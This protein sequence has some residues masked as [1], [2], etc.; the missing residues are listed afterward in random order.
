MTE[1]LGGQ[2]PHSFQFEIAV[3]QEQRQDVL[4]H[5]ATGKGK[6]FVAAAPYKLQHNVDEKRVTLMVSPLI[7]LQDEMVETFKDEFGIDA[8]AINSNHG[9]LNRNV[10]DRVVNGDFRIV[11]LAPEVLL[12][13]IFIDTVLR[14]KKFLQRIYSVV[15]D[16]AHCISHWGDSFRKSYSNVGGIRV[17]LPKNTP[18]IAVSATLTR[19][20]TRDIISKLQLG[21]GS[22]FVYINIG[23]DRD[24][25]SLAVRAIHHAQK[26]LSDVGFVVPSNTQHREDIPKTWIYA[27]DIKEGT[28]ITNYLNE[29]LPDHL[30]N[31]GL[32]REYSAVFN[33]DYRTAAMN[34]F[35]SG[36]IRILVCTDAAGMGCNI[37]DVDVVVQWGLPKTLSSFVQRAGRA[38]RGRGKVGL[39]VLLCEPSAYMVDLTKAPASAPRKKGAPSKL[40]TDAAASAREAS[41]AYAVAHGRNRGGLS[42]QDDLLTAQEPEVDLDT[43]DEGLLYFIQTTACRRR[44]LTKVFDNPPP[45]PSVP[46]CDICSPALL[47]RIRPREKP[48]ASLRTARTKKC[49]P[50]AD[51]ITA[52][53]L[54]RKRAFQSLPG[55][56][57]YAPSTLLPNSAVSDLASM[58]PL[59][60]ET[61]RNWLEPRW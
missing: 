14:N 26:T 41:R 58:T 27:D 22:H 39:A 61:I 6:T 12:S 50:R 42:R 47:D 46:C 1:A 35:R 49:E 3:A 60:A 23:N 30:K 29:C 48:A 21:R 17:F 11:L 55:C 36:S 33:S 10:L 43:P 13:R 7:A 53:R 4:C 15:V 54:W 31:T 25:V 28:A 24:N 20:V 9:G 32:I 19:R 38:A 18:F 44:I 2:T 52:I 40:T 8:V 16:E 59:T 5:A 51:I 57:L 34:Q 56:R 45:A 37:P